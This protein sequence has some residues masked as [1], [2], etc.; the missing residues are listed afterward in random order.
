MR[1]LTG[2]EAKVYAAGRHNQRI[3]VQVLDSSRTW[4]DLTSLVG[5]DWLL[6]VSWDE[7]IDEPVAS[8]TVTLC[9]DSQYDSLALVA[10]TRPNLVTGAYSQLIQV[11]REFKVEVAIL[12]QGIEPVSGDWREVFRGDIRDVD[13]GPNPMRFTG[14][15]L[16]A[17]LQRLF[18]ETERPYGSGAGV[19]V[20]TVMQ[21]IIK[22]NHGT[23]WTANT[24]YSAGSGTVAGAR[25]T[26]TTQNGFWYRCSTSGT[27]HAT[28]EPGVGG[29]PAWPTTIGNTVTNGTA[30]FRCEG[31]CPTLYTPT[32][33]GFLVGTFTQK[34]ESVLDALKRLAMEG[35]GWDVRYRWR[36]GTAQFELTFSTPN[37]AT[38]TAL[39]TFDADHY[40]DVQQLAVSVDTIRNAV[41]VVYP[42]SADLDAAGIPKRKAVRKEDPASQT[43]YTHGQPAFMEIAEPA[44][45]QL[46]TST[47]AGALVDNALSDLAEPVADQAILM[48]YWYPGELWDLYAF[49]ANAVHYDSEQKFAVS[50]LRHDFPPGGG[51]PKTVLLTR[52]KPAVAVMGWLR[53][54]A[55]PG[56]APPA[57]FAAPDAPANLVLTRV[58][59]G[60]VADFEV[61]TKL[62]TP[63]RWT[64]FELHVST[65]SSFTPS[66][67]TFYQRS[68]TN[69]FEVTDLTP[70][71]TYYAKV[72]ARDAKENRSATSSEVSVAAG[73]AT[74]ILMQPQVAFGLFPPNSSFEA[75]NASGSPPDTWSMVTGTWGTDATLEASTVYSGGYAVRFAATAV[76][77]K[78]RSQLFAVIPGR[79]YAFG[80]LLRQTTVVTTLQGD[81]KFYSDLG[82]T[83]VTPPGAIGNGGAAGAW[84][85][86][87]TVA[88]A[89]AGAKYAR[90]ELYKFGAVADECFI[91]SCSV[92]E[93]SF[94]QE[95]WTDKSGAMLGTWVANS[96]NP[97]YRKNSL[98]NVELSGTAKSGTMNTAAF[99][100][101]AGYRPAST[102]RLATMS[103]GAFAVVRVDTNGDVV[104]ETG[105]NADFWLDG[106]QF[107]LN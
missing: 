73:Y 37:R 96:K 45:T 65:S 61:P 56:G 52:G 14:L 94:P 20:Q 75:N 107:P 88:A 24:A 104:P 49:S 71:T 64:E 29:Q 5:K 21:S 57:V 68:T 99:N 81:L 86:A 47:E 1:T 39:H 12:P 80:A 22:D 43:K 58:A 100:L 63:A 105:S 87:S 62:G 19:A 83:E 98:G 38:T 103:N 3:R 78:I 10:A 34:K 11:G 74:P 41:Q 59:G 70:G 77:T 90:V 84:Y 13:Y 26:P 51:N 93:A 7:H 28:L 46:D 36:S 35:L 53:L 92:A 8:C 6:G 2:Q 25:V 69:R 23:A 44:T 89:P 18:I 85:D 66:S 72:V 106:L 32:S 16:G 27:T 60:F 82:T 50:S 67:S 76:A 4:R 48:P 102:V 31:V 54:D 91:D 95:R 101:A 97:R 40:E 55:R 79:S 17:R 42:D 30:V 9:R 33:P 15:D